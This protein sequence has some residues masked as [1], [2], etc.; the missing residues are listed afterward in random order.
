V[1]RMVSGAC[2]ATLA[3]HTYDLFGMEV[4]ATANQDLERTKFTGQERDLMGT[5]GQTDD[6]DTMRVSA[7]EVPDTQERN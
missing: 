1:S 2:A 6:L 4:S 5:S 7:G 3:W